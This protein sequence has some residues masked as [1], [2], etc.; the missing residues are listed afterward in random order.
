MKTKITLPS[1]LIISLLILTG[2]DELEVKTTE[3]YYSVIDPSLDPGFPTNLE[4]DSILYKSSVVKLGTLGLK[5]YGICYGQKENPTVLDNVQFAKD[6]ISGVPF[7]FQNQVKGLKSGTTYQVRSFVITSKDTI[8][9]PSNFFRAVGKNEWVI[10][11]QMPY[12]NDASSDPGLI[13]TFF[14][15]KRVFM[16]Y[17]NENRLWEYDIRKY[18]WIEK[19]ALPS[20]LKTKTNKY[21]FI[22]NG[23]GYCGNVQ[24]SGDKIEQDFWEFDPQLNTW[25]GLETSKPILQST[26]FFSFSDSKFGY[27][28]NLTGTNKWN[29]WRFDPNGANWTLQSEGLDNE[30]VTNL[31][32]DGSN[33]FIITK[34]NIIY[35]FTNQ[36][37]EFFTNISG[38][39][40]NTDG[41]GYYGGTI[42]NKI[43]IGDLEKDKSDPKGE[44]VRTRTWKSIDISTKSIDNL[45]ETNFRPY[46]GSYQTTNRLFFGYEES[47]ALAGDP[48]KV[49]MSEY[50]PK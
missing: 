48:K 9:G 11:E 37:W 27:L 44:K 45:P 10:R 31:F 3:E 20:T 24:K 49:R 42:N 32:S 38:V 19:K 28:L 16:F 22:I 36:R 13:S 33:T 39:L 8:Y 34:N 35:K 43:Y 1:L 7:F 15:D 6:S 4:Q 50:F 12:P 40:Q 5:Y 41:L 26:K 17:Q 18:Y 30:V 21:T 23:K 25:R 29:L 14:D 2:C 47:T 46:T